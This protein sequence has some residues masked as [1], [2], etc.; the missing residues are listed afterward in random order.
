MR[1]VD[2]AI[3]NGGNTRGDAKFDIDGAAGTLAYY[4]GVGK[5]LGDRTFL[6]DGE[7]DGIL[8]SK[9]FVGQHVFVPRHGVAVHLN[10]FNFPAWGMAEKAAVAWLA[11]MPVFAKPGTATSP[12]AV[13]RF[14]T[15]IVPQIAS[16]NSVEPS[17][18]AIDSHWGMVGSVTIPAVVIGPRVSPSSR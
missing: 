12:L 16:V 5:K 10:A 18:I 15:P 6:L 13:A 1:F 7:P 2:I 8:R 4:A 11:G 3:A 9:R 17:R 14:R